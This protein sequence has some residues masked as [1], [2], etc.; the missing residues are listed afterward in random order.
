MAY[1]YC[2]QRWSVICETVYVVS[3]WGTVQSLVFT[4]PHALHSIWANRTSERSN[5]YSS[6]PIRNV[7]SSS[8]IRWM[9][10]PPAKLTFDH[11]WQTNDCSHVMNWKTSLPGRWISGTVALLLPEIVRSCSRYTTVAKWSC[12]WQ[13]IHEMTTTRQPIYSLS[14]SLHCC[15]IRYKYHQQGVLSHIFCVGV[16]VWVSVWVRGSGVKADTRDAERERHH[17]ERVVRWLS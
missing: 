2:G 10:S 3:E 8:F 6:A 12:Y 13:S 11:I 9:K 1:P 16:R 17:Q 15:N 7:D 4:G 14:L 5:H